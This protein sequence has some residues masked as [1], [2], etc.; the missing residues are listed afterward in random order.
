MRF[1]ALLLVGLSIPVQAGYA[2][3]HRWSDCC[4]PAV[5]QSCCVDDCCDSHHHR[6]ARRYHRHH[7]HDHGPRYHRCAA[8]CASP[9]CGFPA[10]PRDGQE[11]RIHG[12]EWE[13]DEDD[14]RWELD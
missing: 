13:W 4:G 3:G 12:V 5:V 11:V 14:Q 10:N 1:L 2:H 6:R 7:R 8:A 9:A